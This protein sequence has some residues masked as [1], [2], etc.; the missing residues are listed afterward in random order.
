MLIVEGIYYFKDELL[1]GGGNK[2]NI[3]LD[4]DSI[5][6]NDMPIARSNEL[7]LSQIHL[8]YKIPYQE[9]SPYFQVQN[10]T[11]VY[12]QKRIDILTSIVE[13]SD[14]PEISYEV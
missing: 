11:T 4:V 2:Y 7:I 1:Q 3:I 14:F 13:D 9:L 10:I 12:S 6:E 8:T 5:S